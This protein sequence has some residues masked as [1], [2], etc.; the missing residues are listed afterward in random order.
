MTLD[1]CISQKLHLQRAKWCG[2]ILECHDAIN[3]FRCCHETCN[4]NSGEAD[5]SRT[6]L[7]FQHCPQ[8]ASVP[9]L[10]V[11]LDTIYECQIQLRTFKN[12]TGKLYRRSMRE[13]YKDTGAWHCASEPTRMCCIQ[14]FEMRVFSICHKRTFIVRR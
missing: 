2:R 8:V 4:S 11:W 10:L 9:Y 12:G 6:R 7:R 13:S 5:G 3:H 1:E 14:Y